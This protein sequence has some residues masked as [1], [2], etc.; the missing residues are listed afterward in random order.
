LSRRELDAVEVWIASDCEGPQPEA[1]AEERRVLAEALEQALDRT[2]LA[3]LAVE[4]LGA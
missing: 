3:R 2:R 1:D 4:R